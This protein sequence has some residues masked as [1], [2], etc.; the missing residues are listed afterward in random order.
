MPIITPPNKAVQE[1]KG[2]HLYHAGFS[3]CAMRVRLTLEEK[4]LSWISL[5]LDIMK[6]EHLTDERFSSATGISKSDIEAATNL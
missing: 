1:F 4:S 5:N 6:G 2:L 3:N